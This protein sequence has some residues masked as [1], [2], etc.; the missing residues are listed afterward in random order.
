MSN[1]PVAWLIGSVTFRILVGR[2]KG[3]RLSGIPCLRP[4]GTRLFCRAKSGWL[5]IESWR[6]GSPRP[7]LKSGFLPLHEGPSAEL[8]HG[9]LPAT[10]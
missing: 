7:G 5:W 3:T 6:V 4:I 2:K 9:V 8:Y 1:E 10:S